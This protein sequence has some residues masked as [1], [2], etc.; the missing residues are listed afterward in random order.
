[1]TID[2]F[3]AGIFTTIFVEM[4]VFIGYGLWITRRKK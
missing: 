2:P 4:F 3:I 1:M